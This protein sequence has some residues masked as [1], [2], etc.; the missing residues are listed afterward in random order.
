M[1]IRI[2][3]IL[4]TCSLVAPSALAGG[5]VTPMLQISQPT[6]TFDFGSV[7]IGGS[8]PLTLGLFA[9][10]TNTGSVQVTA[11][12]STGSAFALSGSC[13]GSAVVAPDGSCNLVETFIPDS[14]GLKTGSVEVTCL[15][16]GTPLVGAATFACNGTPFT[17]SL[18]GYGGILMAVPTLN[19]T[20]VALLAA[21][22]MGWG[23]WF[24]S[25]R[26]RARRH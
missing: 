11:L 16:V 26:Q 12:T 6:P 22:L 2:G 14:Q 18:L 25:R 17:I 21:S 8:K 7:A 9:P 1:R 4:L 13:G 15:L 5:P 19:P 3:L 24:V 10:A 23:A 20:L